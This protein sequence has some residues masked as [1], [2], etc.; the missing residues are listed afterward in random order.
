MA[1]AIHPKVHADAKTKTVQMD[2]VYAEKEERCVGQNVAASMKHVKTAEKFPKYN[3]F[4][5]VN[6]LFKPSWISNS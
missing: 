4:P 1:T 3:S 5:D 6:N 2:A